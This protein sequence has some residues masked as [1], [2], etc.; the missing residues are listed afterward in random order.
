MSRVRDLLNGY[1]LVVI[2][3]VLVLSGYVAGFFLLTDFVPDKNPSL[4]A[5]NKRV[6]P[7]RMLMSLWRPMRL[8]DKKANSTV[9][10]VDSAGNP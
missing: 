7:S 2:G 3:V 10:W 4:D 1:W 8:Y 5:I 6:F 9:H